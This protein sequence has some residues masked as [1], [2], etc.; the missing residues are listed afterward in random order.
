VQTLKINVCAA[1]PATEDCLKLAV[2]IKNPQGKQTLQSLARVWERVA[3]E[4]EHQ[5]LRQID[6]HSGF[7]VLPSMSSMAHP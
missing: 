5:L 3:N 7:D 2:A 1:A 6:I 4:R